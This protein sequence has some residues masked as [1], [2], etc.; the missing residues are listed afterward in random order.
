VSGTESIEIVLTV[1]PNKQ[2]W[3]EVREVNSNGKQVG[4]GTLND[5]NNTITYTVT[6]NAYIIVGN[7]AN[8]DI[9]VNGT[10]IDDGNAAGSKR[11]QFNKVATD[12]TQTDTTNRTTTP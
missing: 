10:V 4:T 11:I 7:A 3:F 12:T 5:A 8:V 1:I 9:T 2:C 6:N